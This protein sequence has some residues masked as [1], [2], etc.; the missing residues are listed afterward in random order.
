MFLKTPAA[1]KADLDVVDDYFSRILGVEPDHSAAAEVVRS[2]VQAR[3]E[4]YL[5]Q[6]WRDWPVAD[7]IT[8]LGVLEP[9]PVPEEKRPRGRPRKSNAQQQ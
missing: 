4:D 2:L 9:T 7:L 1:A 3:C 5:R 8:L 6:R